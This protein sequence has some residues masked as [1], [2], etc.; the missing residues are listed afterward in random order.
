M[1]YIGPVPIYAI[2]FLAFFTWAYANRIPSSRRHPLRGFVV[3]IMITMLLSELFAGI[4]LGTLLQPIYLIARTLL[5]I[6]LFYSI[7]K[8][9][10]NK[11]DLETML[12]GGLPGAVITAALMIGSSLPQTQSMVARYVFLP[13]I[14]IAIQ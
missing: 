5:A 7:P 1:S 6:S 9:I 8:I 12:K 11:S 3:F 13:F 4:Q 10:R 2:D 14:F